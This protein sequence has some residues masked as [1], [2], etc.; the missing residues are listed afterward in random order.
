MNHQ[1]F[2]ELERLMATNLDSQYELL[3]Q[4]VNPHLLFNSLNTLKYMVESQDSHSTEFILKLG[5]FYRSTL[6]R[7][8]LK[9]LPRR[10]LV[11]AA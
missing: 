4:Q 10:I 8:K 5:A 1:V 3:K 7:L 11:F 6:D 9:I 2:A